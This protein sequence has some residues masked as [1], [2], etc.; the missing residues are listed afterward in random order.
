MRRP[1]SPQVRDSLGKISP[2][3]ALCL[4]RGFHIVHYTC[5]ARL[6]VV[7][8]G[9]WSYCRRLLSRVI[10][11]RLVART[12][13]SVIDSEFVVAVLELMSTVE[14]LLFEF[15]NPLPEECRFRRFARGRRRGRPVRRGLRTGA[16]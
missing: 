6:P 8:G 9:A 1:A 12:A 10:R 15:G 11:S 3:L 5:C 2:D 13:A 7:R 4:V 14:E 16:R